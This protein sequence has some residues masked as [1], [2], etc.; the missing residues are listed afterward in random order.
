MKVNREL[1]ETVPDDPIM[2]QVIAMGREVFQTAFHA[3]SSM[4][5]VPEWGRVRHVHLLAAV[6]R[7]FGIEI[8]GED[9][10]RLG[11][12]LAIVAYVRER[13]AKMR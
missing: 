12:A 11:S 3:G 5:T 8:A 2:Q 1:V 7:R 10:A 4:D 6:E 13:R 9:A